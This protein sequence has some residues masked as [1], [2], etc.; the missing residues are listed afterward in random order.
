MKLLFVAGALGIDPWPPSPSGDFGVVE[1][2]E[3]FS[4]SVDFG[5]VLVVVDEVLVDS[6]GFG[7]GLLFCRNIPE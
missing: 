7:V 3:D 2:V 6:F 5:V 1:V 4:P